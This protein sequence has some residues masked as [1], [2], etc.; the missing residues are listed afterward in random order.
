MFAVVE[1]NPNTVSNLI[2]F[3]IVNKVSLP[4]NVRRVEYKWTVL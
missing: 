4:I 1:I 3:N 2:K